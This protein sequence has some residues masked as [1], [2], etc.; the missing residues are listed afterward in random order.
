[1][2]NDFELVKEFVATFAKFDELIERVLPVPR[3]LGDGEPDEYG[4]QKWRP[5]LISTDAS[6]LEPLYARLGAR[7][8][9]LYEKLVVSYRWAEV[10]LDRF[11]LLANPPGPNLD[12]LLAGILRV[13]AFVEILIPRGYIPFGKRA[14]GHFDPLCFD[15]QKREGRRTQKRRRKQ[16]AECRIVLLDHEEV[17]CNGRIRELEEL[18]PTFRQL[19]LSTIERAA[20]LDRSLS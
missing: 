11:A 17:L 12:G 2:E 10:E 1:M 13:P 5:A 15:L 14:G 18:A 19:L 8:P 7:F 9:P 20:K 6:A 16:N 4:W 3:E